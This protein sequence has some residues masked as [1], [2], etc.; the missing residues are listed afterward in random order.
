M[1]KLV[2][3]FWCEQG[4]ADAVRDRFIA[5]MPQPMRAA[6]A[7]H[8][9]L[10]VT[11]SSIDPESVTIIHST[12]PAPAGIVTF[13]LDSAYY[14][15]EVEELLIGFFPRVSGYSVVESEV[16]R[17]TE[18]PVPLGQRSWGF[19]L[20]TILVK[21][22]AM[23]YDHWLHTWLQLHTGEALPTQSTYRYLRNVVFRPLTHAA[24]NYHGIIEE[25]FPM[26]AMNDADVWFNG[27]GD[28]ATA[29]RNRER[30]E[31]SSRRFI[32]FSR[33]DSLPM[34]EFILS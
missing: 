10:C 29:Q 22:D 19:T 32:D 12:R 9:K 34:S 30:I 2:Y 6:G 18:H 24:P 16:L 13:W 8:I 25:G 3:V 23:D 26:A 11:D 14:K 5:Q 20:V 7:R 15:T 21:P 31:A 33:I 17:N 28:P 4:Q 1:Q 27:G